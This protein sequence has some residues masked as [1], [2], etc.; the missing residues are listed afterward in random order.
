MGVIPL[1]DPLCED[2]KATIADAKK[3]GISVKMA[4]GDQIAIAKE[5]ASQLGLGSNI[6]NAGLFAKTAHHQEG[7]IADAIEQADGFAQVFPE[8][9]YHKD[10]GFKNSESSGHLTCQSKNH[11]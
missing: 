7:Q 8:H 10:Y 5:T 11:G 1:F 6:L 9:K 3:M 2:S 4:T